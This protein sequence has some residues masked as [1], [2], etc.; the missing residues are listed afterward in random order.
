MKKQILP[1]GRI[2]IP[3]WIR[4]ELNITDNEILSIELNKGRIIIKKINN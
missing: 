2:Q 1:D 4:K 3:K